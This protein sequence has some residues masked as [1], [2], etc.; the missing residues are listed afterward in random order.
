MSPETGE[1]NLFWQ[2][3]VYRVLRFFL[4]RAASFFQQ[5]FPLLPNKL[6]VLGV[7]QP[8]L[9]ATK[10]DYSCGAQ[11]NQTGK[12][13]QN[14]EADELAMRDEDARGV[15]RLLQGDFEQVPFRRSEQLL[16]SVGR[17]GVVLRIKPKRSVLHR[18]GT[19]RFGSGSL[20]VMEGT[21]G[22][23]EP[24]LANAA[25]G[26]VRLTDAHSLIGTRPARAGREA[27]GFVASETG[28]AR[29]TG[30]REGQ[31]VVCAVATVEARVGLAAA[32]ADVAEGS[33][34][35]RRTQTGR[36][37]CRAAGLKTCAPILTRRAE[38]HNGT[39]SAYCRETKKTRYA[40]YHLTLAYPHF[41]HVI[42]E[43]GWN[44][45]KDLI[46]TFQKVRARLEVIL[47]NLPP[48][49]TFQTWFFFILRKIK[50]VLRRLANLPES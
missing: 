46:R 16:K 22:T 20:P 13:G 27:V 47:I 40:I 37:G 29:R 15:D 39:M 28:E 48:Y 17:K 10:E 38:G 18:S 42:E 44:N 30:T 23:C 8:R 33:G 11:D 45:A 36:A 32:N 19:C 14:A 24:F 4:A 5:V 12:Q 6:A 7:G 25:E 31:A 3:D 21:G 2:D 50:T 34:K 26:S 1:S 43:Q 49:T 9:A 41:I 35:S